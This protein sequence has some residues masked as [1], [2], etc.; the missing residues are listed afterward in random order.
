MK[1]VTI[2]DLSFQELL[3]AE[4]IAQRVQTIGQ[5]LTQEFRD[6]KPIFIGILNG[7]FIYMADLMRAC[8]MNCELAFIQL[9]SYDGLTTTGKV[10]TLMDL[11]IDLKNRH[12]II[13][14]DIIDTGNTL[15]QFLP[16]LEQLEPASITLT[17]LLLKPD[18][19]QHD[20][21]IHHVGFEIDN[22]FVIGYG[23]DYKELGRNL[24]G[25]YQLA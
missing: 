17:T 20:L 19:L 11:N 14:E 25:V 8:D 4:Q 3:S 16:R 6:K 12:I 23:L 24:T 9:S 18:A 1:T 13:A 15:H 7:A 21:T 5:A 22:L 2:K 10:K